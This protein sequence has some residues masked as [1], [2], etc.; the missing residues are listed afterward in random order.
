[1]PEIITVG[2]DLAKNVFQA[3]QADRAE[4]PVLRKKLRWGQVPAFFSELQPCVVTMRDCGGAHHLGRGIS[5]PGH[6]ARLIP[7]ANVKPFVKQ[8]KNDAADAPES[9]LP[10]GAIPTLKVLIAA[11]TPMEAE[12]AKLNAGLRPA[13]L[14]GHR[15]LALPPG[16]FRKARDFAA[17][18]SLT[19]RQHSTGSKQRL[20]AA[21]RYNI[22]N[23]PSYSEPLMHHWFEHNGER[24]KATRI[25]VGLD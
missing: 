21:T 3:R 14:Y 1:M 20:G 6:D 15:T 22:T 24:T 17:W 12:I 7:P 10:A 2:L 5:M 18:P 25:A 13:D 8:Q 11:L 23:W 16:T 4:Q 19:R 9:G